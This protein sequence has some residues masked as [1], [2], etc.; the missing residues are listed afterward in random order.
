VEKKREIARGTTGLIL[1]A[2]VENKLVLERRDVRYK[3]FFV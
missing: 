3:R 2:F 1:I